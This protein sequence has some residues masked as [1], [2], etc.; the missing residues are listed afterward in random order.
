[1]TGGWTELIVR[2]GRTEPPG[3]E[4]ARFAGG[5]ADPVRRRL[6][7]RPERG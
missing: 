3:S 2:A 5:R 7:R 4:G 6:C 1:M